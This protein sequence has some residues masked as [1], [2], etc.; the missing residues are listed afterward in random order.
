MSFSQR[1]SGPPE[2]PPVRPF[3]HQSGVRRSRQGGKPDFGGHAAPPPPSRTAREFRRTFAGPADNRPEDPSLSPHRPTGRMAKPVQV[4]P[5]IYRIGSD[6]PVQPG[7]IAAGM[8]ED[9]N[10]GFN[11]PHGPHAGN[12]QPECAE[13][14]GADPITAPGCTDSDAGVV[15]TRRRSREPGLR[16]P[17]CGIFGFRDEAALDAAVAMIESMSPVDARY[18]GDGGWNSVTSVWVQWVVHSPDV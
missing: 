2:T 15:R 11:Q 9:R 18:W 6:R 13:G 1:G 16:P 17:R 7:P 4:L 12:L 5:G 8:T 10:G 14:T 3:P